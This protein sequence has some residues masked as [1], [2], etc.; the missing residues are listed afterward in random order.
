MQMD[1]GA[2]LWL[3]KYAHANYWRVPSW[4]SEKDLVQDGYMTYWRVVRRYDDKVRR[5]SHMMSLFKIC[6]INHVHDL[7]KNKT[8]C[9]GEIPLPDDLNVIEDSCEGVS[10]VIMSAPHPVQC[11]IRALTT[12]KGQEKLRKPFRVGKRGRE[13]T[14]TRWCRVAGVSSRGIDLPKL[15]KKS[16]TKGVKKK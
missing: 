12:D 16:I 14:N 1:D 8:K 13:T 7:S 9:A 3:F 6:F 4:Y 5:R 2:R 10:D 15:V 11:L